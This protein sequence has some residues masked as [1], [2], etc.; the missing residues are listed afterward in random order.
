MSGNKYQ[1]HFQQQQHLHNEQLV[2]VRKKEQ[3]W[4]KQK[5]VLWDP[6][7]QKETERERVKQ[8]KNQT[9]KQENRKKNEIEEMF[10][11]METNSYER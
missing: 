10:M 9:N 8:N 7:C 11:V 5:W 2:H 4:G 3:T 1:F 6:V